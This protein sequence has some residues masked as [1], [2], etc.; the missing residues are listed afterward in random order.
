MSISLRET[1]PTCPG[2]LINFLPA[3]DNCYTP[4]SA[5]AKSIQLGFSTK[6]A[7]AERR[8]AGGRS[9]IQQQAVVMI[10]IPREAHAEDGDNLF[11]GRAAAGNEKLSAKKK[12]KNQTDPEFK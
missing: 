3:T 1:I 2:L 8:I 5:S 7:C 12:E 6:R 4:C 9:H 10:L 11:G